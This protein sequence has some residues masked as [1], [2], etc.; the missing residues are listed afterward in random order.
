MT[1]VVEL[2]SGLECLRVAAEL[3]G[4]RERPRAEMTIVPR[5]R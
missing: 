3:A 4:L 2:E 1:D 5:L